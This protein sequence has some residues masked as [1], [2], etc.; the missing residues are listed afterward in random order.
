MTLPMTSATAPHRPMPRS[1][2]A[3]ADEVEAAGGAFRGAAGADV[4]MGSVTAPPGESSAVG[5]A[6]GRHHTLPTAADAGRATMPR[7]GT[8][9]RVR[10]VSGRASPRSSPPSSRPSVPCRRRIHRDAL[11]ARARASW[12]TFETALGSVSP[13]RTT[14]RKP[15]GRDTP[16]AA[17]WSG[18]CGPTCCS[19][20]CRAPRE[21]VTFRQVEEVDGA[22]AADDASPSIRDRWPTRRA[23]ST[24]ASGGS[25]G[26][27]PPTTSATSSG[28]STRR[29]SRPIV[30][31]RP[32]AARVRFRREARQT[33]DGQ[34]GRDRA[35]RRNGAA[36]HRP[37]TR[38]AQRAD[39]RPAV[40][41]CRPPARCCDR[42]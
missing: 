23:R 17:R 8:D 19:S 28:R 22:A 10:A 6:S 20:R 5:S 37:R 39:A 21:W 24:H 9:R 29:R 3:S 11:L 16:T 4:V 33:I 35:L 14:G 12:A 32:H 34:R 18:R 41:G 27:A 36:D 1:S 38:D 2:W 7:D 30:L 31:R 40:A 26:P 15:A 13:T 25:C 42:R